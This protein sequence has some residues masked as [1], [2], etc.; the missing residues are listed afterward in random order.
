MLFMAD[1]VAD[2]EDPKIT[3]LKEEES[4]VHFAIYDGDELQKLVLLNNEYYNDTLHS[5]RGSQKVDVSF[6]GSNLG[7]RRLTGH[8]SDVTTGVTWATQS[9]D[10]D[11]N[12]VGDLH[13]EK[14]C[15]G[16][17]TLLDSEAVIVEKL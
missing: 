1:L 2:L 10:D 12:I 7:V 16:F 11:G 15:G 9:T 14:V 5:A 6:L 8:H 17:V 13:I 3:P 4:A